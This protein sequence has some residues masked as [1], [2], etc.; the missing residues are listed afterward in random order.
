V[1][2]VR[3]KHLNPR[4]GWRLTTAAANRHLEETYSADGPTKRAGRH[5]LRGFPGGASL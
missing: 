3:A 2:V 4:R 5:P 1:G